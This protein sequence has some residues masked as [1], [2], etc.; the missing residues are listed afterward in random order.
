MFFGQRFQRHGRGIRH[1]NGTKV[2]VVFV[3]PHAQNI[4]RFKVRLALITDGDGLTSGQNVILKALKK[5]MS[6]GCMLLFPEDEV[7][8]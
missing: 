7:D 3:T 5:V 1:L 4:T 6:F 8:E 2:A